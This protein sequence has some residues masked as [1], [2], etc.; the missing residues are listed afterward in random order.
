LGCLPQAFFKADIVG[1][2]HQIVVP[3]ADR[4]NPQFGFQHR[5]TFGFGFG[6]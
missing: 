3:P 6:F 2:F 4:G 1:Q 5:I